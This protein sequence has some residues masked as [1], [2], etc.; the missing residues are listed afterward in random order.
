MSD[1]S[2]TRARATELVRHRGDAAAAAVI[3][4][5][6]ESARVYTSPEWEL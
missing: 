2:R 6:E 1:C 4:V 3:D 5:V